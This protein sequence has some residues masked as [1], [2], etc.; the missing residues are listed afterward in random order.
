[1]LAQRA[2]VGRIGK[3]I[4]KSTLRNIVSLFPKQIPMQYLTGKG[5][6]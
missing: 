4:A 6:C 3:I 2:R 5:I 1:M